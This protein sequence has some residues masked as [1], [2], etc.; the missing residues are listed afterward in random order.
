MKCGGRM[1]CTC[2]IRL[3]RDVWVLDVGRWVLVILG[4][5]VAVLTIIGVGGLGVKEP[6]LILEFDSAFGIIQ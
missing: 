4:R 6:M 3:K 2:V 1:Q 5:I